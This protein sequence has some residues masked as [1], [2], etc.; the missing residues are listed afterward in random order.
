M[1][2]QWAARRRYH[3]E[4]RAQ[5]HRHSL[6]HY[7]YLLDGHGTIHINNQLF[8]LK[9]NTLYATPMGLVH[10]YKPMPPKGIY[11]VELKFT[12]DDPELRE[13]AVSLAYETA[14]PD[15][16]IRETLSCIISEGVHAK[17]FHDR[18]IHLKAE[19]LMLILMRNSAPGLPVHPDP[20]RH[21][22]PVN[23]HLREV[24]AYMEENFAQTIDLHDLADMACY[25]TTY[26][27][28]L[29]RAKTGKSPISYLINTRIEN[30]KTLFGET[31]MNVSEVG[32][33]V[34]FESIPYF[35]RCFSRRVG[36]TPKQYRNSFRDDVYIHIEED[37]LA[38][39]GVID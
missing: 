32:Y 15:G 7:I 37:E 28:T 17:P 3:V 39:S 18:L 5:P 38:L 16:I 14:D 21:S 30:A 31:D 9:K 36:Q 12:V 1:H 22:H 34:G 23:R 27:C 24:I 20:N 11:T 10:N 19:E 6:F 33:A 26:F 35:S 4:Y 29:F 25:T 13:R 8:K 2:V